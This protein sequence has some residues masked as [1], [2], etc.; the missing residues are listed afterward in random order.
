MDLLQNK[1]QHS[2]NA[3]SNDIIDLPTNREEIQMCVAYCDDIESIVTDTREYRH[4]RFI[5]LVNNGSPRIRLTDISKTDAPITTKCKSCNLSD[6]QELCDWELVDSDVLQTALNFKEEL[7]SWNN[8]PKELKKKI[9][10]IINGYLTLR[11]NEMT[12]RSQMNDIRNLFKKA[13]Q[14]CDPNSIIEA[15]TTSQSFTELLNKD[16][17][18]IVTHDI[19]NGCS[20]F[21]C[22]ILYTTQD[23]TKSIA[24]I[25]YH[26]SDFIAHSGTFYRGIV[27]S[28]ELP[29]LQV[30]CCVMTNTFISTS[31]R[32][33]IADIFSAFDQTSNQQDQTRILIFCT[34]IIKNLN[35]TC[36]ALDIS[37]I[38]KHPEEEEVLILPYSVFRITKRKTTQLP[39]AQSKRIE[40]E[41]EQYDESELRS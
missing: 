5:H 27:L 41:L 9:F 35:G 4:S 19:Q 38:S 8:N 40:I 28:H 29:H 26:H 11:L 32:P 21:S 23:G 7:K 18:R 33:N 24:S 2:P 31:K 12:D 39:N 13:M 3:P 1:H 15:Y 34:Y 22:D 6:E 17:A 20:Q 14:E 25:L 37:S 16:M 30:N 36:R 10:S